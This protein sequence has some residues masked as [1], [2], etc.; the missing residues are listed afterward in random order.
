MLGMRTSLKYIAEEIDS[1]EAFT[2][3]I[4]QKL[5]RV[6]II[7]SSKGMNGGFN[8]SMDRIKSTTL[9][10]IVYAIDGLDISNRCVLGLSQCSSINPCSVHHKFKPV[11]EDLIALL[12]KTTVEEM[13]IGIKE[14]LAILR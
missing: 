13:A 3:K 5:V 7:E 2:A 1:P 6:K 8:M 9:S 14:K 11:R 4:L 12:T 10:E